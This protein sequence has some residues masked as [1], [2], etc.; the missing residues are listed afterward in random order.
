MAIA[1]FLYQIPHPEWVGCVLL[2][3][4]GSLPF[5]GKLFDIFKRADALLPVDELNHLNAFV[6]LAPI[7]FF[8]LG[9]LSN[10]GNGLSKST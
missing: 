1:L 6:F 7:N 3:I 10:R 2:G 5:F 4:V 8:S 9:V